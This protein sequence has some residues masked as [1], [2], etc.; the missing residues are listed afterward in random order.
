MGGG[1]C[2]LRLAVAGSRN[3]QHDEQRKAFK[4]HVELDSHLFWK[5]D[6]EAPQTRTG[7]HQR[8]RAPTLDREALIDVFEIN[9]VR[10]ATQEWPISRSQ[11]RHVAANGLDNENVTVLW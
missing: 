11:R 7:V 8:N 6:V 5:R 10:A 2:E 3:L 9:G 1:R 4:R